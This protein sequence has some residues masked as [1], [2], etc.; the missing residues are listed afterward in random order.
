[1][2]RDDAAHGQRSGLRPDQRGKVRRLGQDQPDSAIRS[3]AVVSVRAVSRATACTRCGRPRRPWST[4]GCSGRAF[5]GASSLLFLAGLSIYGGM[6]LLPL[7]FQQ[8]GGASAPA[9][10]L[11]MVP[12]GLR[13][14]LPRTL[15]GK[16]T[17]KIGPRLVVLWCTGFTVLAMLPAL[18]LS[19][20]GDGASRP[21]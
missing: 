1:V 8:V 21:A 9:A 15:A 5:T 7:Y 2:A 3:G 13:S 19:G 14:L 16:L 20:R 11:L 4:C 17:E 12:Q 10:G 18:L 6:L